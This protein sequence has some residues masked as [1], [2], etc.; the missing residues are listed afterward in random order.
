V[1]GSEAGLFN[2]SCK[3]TDV[4]TNASL[5]SGPRALAVAS[6]IICEHEERSRK[7]GNDP[8]PS[9]VVGPGAMN[10]HHWVPGSRLFAIEIEP[11]DF[12]SGHREL[13]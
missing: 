12:H 13:L 1:D 2:Q 3:I 9:V 7:H 4:L 6:P 8:V 10:K 11:V 5:L